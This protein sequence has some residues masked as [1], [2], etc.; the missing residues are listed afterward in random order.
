MQSSHCW[1]AGRGEY[2]NYTFVTFPFTNKWSYSNVVF[3]A[4]LCLC[5]MMNHLSAHHVTLYSKSKGPPWDGSGWRG[6]YSL[7]SKF[8]SCD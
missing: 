4:V 5:C 8:L 3:Y 7:V 6:R 2:N 1:L